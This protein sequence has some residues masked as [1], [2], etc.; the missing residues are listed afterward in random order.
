MFW[1]VGRE[2]AVPRRKK[3]ENASAE[4]DGPR[5]GDGMRNSACHGYEVIY[6]DTMLRV[7]TG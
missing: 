7:D 3:K 4:E 1:N 6:R 2:R 5:P